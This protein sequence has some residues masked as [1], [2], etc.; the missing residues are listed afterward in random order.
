M[1]PT[2]ERQGL[3]G[4]SELPKLLR[5]C[6]RAR[7]DGGQTTRGREVTLGDGPK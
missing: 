4:F 3:R 6:G 7:R 1:G 2:M 5:E